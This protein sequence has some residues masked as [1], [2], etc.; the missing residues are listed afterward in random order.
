VILRRKAAVSDEY[1]LVLLGDRGAFQSDYIAVDQHTREALLAYSQERNGSEALLDA[2]RWK[3]ELKKDNSLGFLLRHPDSP[4]RTTAWVIL[5][6]SIFS[7]V[8]SILF[9]K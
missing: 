8:Q 2:T 9:E 4:V 7:I 5:V 6:T 3:I 1:K